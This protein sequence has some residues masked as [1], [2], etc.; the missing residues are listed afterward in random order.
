[1]TLRRYTALAPLAPITSEW[2]FKKTDLNC[3]GKVTHEVEVCRHLII[4][5]NQP[6]ADFDWLP[7]YLVEYYVCVVRYRGVRAAAPGV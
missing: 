6:I 4:R 1:L 2:P 5:I 7:L 3:L